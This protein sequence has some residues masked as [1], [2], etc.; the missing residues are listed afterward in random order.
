MNKVSVREGWVKVLN[1]VKSVDGRLV[2]GNNGLVES[3]N[4]HLLVSKRDTIELTILDTELSETVLNIV[5]IEG[6]ESKVSF[7]GVVS[8]FNDI[9][10]SGGVVSLG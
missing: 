1:A 4:N 10:I 7:D 6:R 9:R 5:T 8:N 2:H 3:L